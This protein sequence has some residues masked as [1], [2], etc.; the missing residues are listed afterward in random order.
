[1]AD[2]RPH[3][4]K[5]L[6]LTAG[7]ARLATS[8]RAFKQASLRAKT[9]SLNSRARTAAVV[10]VGAPTSNATP[11]AGLISTPTS[12]SRIP[13]IVSKSLIDIASSLQ[14]NTGRSRAYISFRSIV[15]MSDAVTHGYLTYDATRNRLGVN[16]PLLS[17]PGH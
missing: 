6:R 14:D 17:I 4:S 1:M 16:D 12:T 8:L 13:E 3:S 15:T 2:L 7:P 5:P 9:H 10:S 11:S